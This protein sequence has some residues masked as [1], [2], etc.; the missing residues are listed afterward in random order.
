MEEAEERFEKL[1]GDDY[2]FTQDSGD[3]KI[4]AIKHQKKIITQKLKISSATKE[5]L[6]VKTLSDSEEGQKTSKYSTQNISKADKIEKKDSSCS[7][8]EGTTA[9]RNNK[10][11]K[12]Y[13]KPTTET[14]K[15]RKLKLKKF[16]KKGIESEET[17]SS[18]S[19]EDENNNLSD[20]KVKTDNN[21]M[22]N[23]K[24]INKDAEL[25]KS[26]KSENL[27]K[28]SKT[29]EFK[30]PENNKHCKK[31]SQQHKNS[32]ESDVL[33]L[34]Q[35]PK[36][37]KSN[38]CGKF[39]IIFIFFDLF[40]EIIYFYLFS[41]FRY[42]FAELVLKKLDVLK[43]DMNRVEKKLDKLLESHSAITNVPA[44][45]NF[46]T[47]YELVLPMSNEQEFT[48]FNDRLELEEDF[49]SG[50]VSILK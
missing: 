31:I 32:R 13:K 44:V 46:I 9:K 10:I 40:Y 47:K 42:L 27:S 23:T 22:C 34:N 41:L 3:P 21:N 5:A 43:S 25:E 1:G 50:F 45:P 36:H 4:K 15:N 17:P 18:L 2:A 16:S 48:I 37:V 39:T 11:K 49:C 29:S 6:K 38:F 28:E 26:S 35:E 12:H 24:Y 20:P 7:S 33:R 30:I 8:S 19:S 14:T